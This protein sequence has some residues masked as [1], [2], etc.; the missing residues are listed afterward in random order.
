VAAA[1]AAVTVP[2][3]WAVKPTAGDAVVVTVSASPVAAAVVTDGAGVASALRRSR[4]NG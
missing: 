4:K 1:A 3:L 2:P